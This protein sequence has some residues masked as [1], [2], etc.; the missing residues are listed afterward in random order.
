MREHGRL[1]KSSP[2]FSCAEHKYSNTAKNYMYEIVNL[3]VKQ[4]RIYNALM[5]RFD[6][7]FTLQIQ[8]KKARCLSFFVEKHVVKHANCRFI[9]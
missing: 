6:I 1:Y 9:I 7:E 2:S 5:M 8:I 3:E 4:K